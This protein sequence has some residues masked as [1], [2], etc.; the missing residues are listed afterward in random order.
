[1]YLPFLF[2]QNL[3]KLNNNNNNSHVFRLGMCVVHEYS[4]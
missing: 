2:E 1:M 4:E 3:C